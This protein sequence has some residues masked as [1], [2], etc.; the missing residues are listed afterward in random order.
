M[1]PTSAS[2]YPGRSSIRTEATV[3]RLSRYYLRAGPKW[4]ASENQIV[5]GNTVNITDGFGLLHS[6]QERARRD[7]LNMESFGSYGLRTLTADPDDTKTDR[8]FDITIPKDRGMSVAGDLSGLVVMVEEAT[9]SGRRPVQQRR[10]IRRFVTRHSTAPMMRRP[11][12]RVTRDG[13][14]TTSRRTSR[15]TSSSSASSDGG[16]DLP[17]DP[18]PVGAEGRVSESA[19]SLG[20]LMVTA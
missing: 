13:R 9:D 16:S 20:E 6:P 8:T 18:A 19:Q 10:H 5:G 14:N 17:Q 4:S 1:Q 7:A 2:R 12:R 15:M 3:I 11:Q